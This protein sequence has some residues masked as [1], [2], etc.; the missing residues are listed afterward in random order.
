[1]L[2][3]RAGERPLCALE[4]VGAPVKTPKVAQNGLSPALISSN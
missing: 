2:E 3:M 1:M 4:A